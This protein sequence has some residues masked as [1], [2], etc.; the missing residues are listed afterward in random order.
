MRGFSSHHILLIY[1]Q[2]KDPHQNGYI[3][4]QGNFDVDT[5]EESKEMSQI[6]TA[7]VSNIEMISVSTQTCPDFV[8]T[9]SNNLPHSNLT[10]AKIT[11][12]TRKGDTPHANHSQTT[13]K[14]KFAYPHFITFHFN[15]D[16]PVTYDHRASPAIS[17]PKKS[18]LKH[19][20][21]ESAGVHAI[22]VFS[23]D[24][25]PA[26][27]PTFSFPDDHDCLTK[28]QTQIKYSNNDEPITCQAISTSKSQK[29]RAKLRKTLEDTQYE[30]ITSLDLS[31]QSNK[32]AQSK[33]PQCR[34]IALHSPQARRLH[35][36][37]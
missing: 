10:S 23:D 5:L 29:R 9:V 22:Q 24:D 27:S 33:D 34:F 36:Y 17:S 21:I 28:R 20:T 15:R 25:S 2:F 18:I 1:N 37:K 35:S 4:S 14:A 16:S 12:T 30:P 26:Y 19:T 11:K 3:L 7:Y 13:K 31:P 32:K 8:S 6:T